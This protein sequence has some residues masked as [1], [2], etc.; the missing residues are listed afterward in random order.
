M[1]IIAAIVFL[2]SILL[3]EMPHFLKKRGYLA[4]HTKKVDIFYILLI[5]IPIIICV[6]AVI[7]YFSNP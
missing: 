1:E 5:A 6:V 7:N 4:E 2:I 3:I